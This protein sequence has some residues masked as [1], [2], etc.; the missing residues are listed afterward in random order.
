M[1]ITRK[2]LEPVVARLNRETNSPA[3]PWTCGEDGKYRANI[4]NYRLSGAYGGWSLHRM[5]NESGG[6][7]DV[8]S[9]GHVPARDLYNQLHAYLR[10]IEFAKAGTADKECSQ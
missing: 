10:G 2:H 9:C 6:V 5:V 4:G 8:F 3:S 1:R 7:S